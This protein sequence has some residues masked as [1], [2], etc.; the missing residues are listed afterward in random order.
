MSFSGERPA[1]PWDNED[2]DIQGLREDF[3]QNREGYERTARVWDPESGKPVSDPVPIKRS[4][5]G[6]LK[7]P[8]GYL[9]PTGFSYE[10]EFLWPLVEPGSSTGSADVA[11]LIQLGEYAGGVVLD[12]KT[13]APRQLSLDEQLALRHLEFAHLSAAYEALARWILRNPEPGTGARS[14]QSVSIGR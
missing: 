1:S 2:D 14:K 8:E 3:E 12:E 9:R 13:G 10:P 4:D 7:C 5:L 11:A 6:K